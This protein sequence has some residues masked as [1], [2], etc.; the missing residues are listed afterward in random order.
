MHARLEKGQSFLVTD[1]QGGWGYLPLPISPH[2]FSAAFALLF[3]ANTRY[4]PFFRANAYLPLPIATLLQCG[5]YPIHHP[6]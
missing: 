4:L 6:R 5:I 1:A 2:F 3:M